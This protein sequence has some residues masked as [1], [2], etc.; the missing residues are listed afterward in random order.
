MAFEM[1]VFWLSLSLPGA[2]DLGDAQ[3]RAAASDVDESDVGLYVGLP[4]GLILDRSGS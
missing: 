4:L 3:H 2:L 1:E